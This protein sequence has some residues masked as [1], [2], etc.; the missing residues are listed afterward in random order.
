ME[1]AQVKAN[2]VYGRIRQGEDF[3]A[4]AG[5]ESD[6]LGSRDNG[7]DL[8][9]NPQGTFFPEFEEAAYGLALD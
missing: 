8:C 9:F 1:A 4:L 5:D 2:E 3:S 7:G 6:D